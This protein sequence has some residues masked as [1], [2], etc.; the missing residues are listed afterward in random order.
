MQAIPIHRVFR[1][2]TNVRWE[3][4]RDG[5]V[6][7]RGK[8]G[9]HVSS[10]QQFGGKIESWSPEDL[11]VAA[12]NACVMQTFLAYALRANLSLVSYESA[13][14]GVLERA[15]GRYRFTEFNVYPVLV[16]RTEADI[17][18]ARTIMESAESSCLIS[19]S[20]RAR[21]RV[22]PDFRVDSARESAMR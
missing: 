19:E 8:P 10:P 13:A 14:E 3:S 16:L 20:I 9:L 5:H 6:S 15:E 18:R 7:A 21:V 4:G 17:E 2:E 11:F 1:F 22:V 12:V